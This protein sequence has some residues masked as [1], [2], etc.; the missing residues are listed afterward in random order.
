MNHHFSLDPR[1]VLGVGEDA[2][3]EEI[4]RAFRE[5][6]KKHHPDVGGDEWAF[7][8]V[9]RAHEMLKATSGMAQRHPSFSTTFPDPHGAVS[10]SHA[11]APFRSGQD[12]PSQFEF[13]TVDVELV[14]I[15]FELA[16]RV[17]VYGD[18]MPATTTLSVCL[19]ISWPR[20][21]FV[22]HSAAFPDAAETLHHVIDSFEHLRTSEL[23]PASRC[24]IEEGQFVGWLSYP[25]VLQAEAGFHALHS[26]LALH[27]L[28]VSLQTRD[29]PIPTEWLKR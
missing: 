11:E 18:E 17:E 13:H 27:D 1:T 26:A 9:R 10:E 16:G 2:S 29:E 4:D 3:R 20:L 21:S 5:K 14:W 15:R 22:K 23:H 28:K 19:V 7:R 24:R 6:S 8:V 25:N 12:P